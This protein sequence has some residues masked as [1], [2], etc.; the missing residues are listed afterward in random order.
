MKSNNS[1]A[2]IISLAITTLVLMVITAGTWM[3]QSLQK[4]L[5]DRRWPS[6]HSKIRDEIELTL[7]P[8]MFL[9]ESLAMLFAW[10]E[11]RGMNFDEEFGGKTVQAS[12]LINPQDWHYDGKVQTGG[13]WI[14]FHAFEHDL[15]FWFGDDRP[16]VLN[17]VCVFATV[18]HDGSRAAFWLDDDGK[19]HE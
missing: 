12:L 3:G 13:T 10:L 6:P 15:E 19:Q 8:G 14:C 5:G 2:Q 17:R 18:G 11:D 4:S 9:P 16:E 7:Q 1:S